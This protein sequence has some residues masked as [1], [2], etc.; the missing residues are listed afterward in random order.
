[1]TLKNGLKILK[2]GQDLSAEQSQSVFDDIFKGGT[3]DADIEELLVGLKNKGESVSEIQGAVTSMR[4]HMNKIASPDGCVDI[5]GTGGDGHSTLNVSTAASFVVAGYGVP[6][7]KHGNRAASSLSGS[8][9]VLSAL[10]LNLDPTWESLETALND[11]GIVFLFAPNHHPAMRHVTAVRKKLK[12]RTIFNLLGPLTNPACVKHHLIG[13]FDSAWS[14]PMALTLQALA[15]ENAWITHGADAMDE[16]STTGNT[17]V[18]TL[19]NGVIGR[20]TI[21]PE[22]HAIPLAT[23]KDIQGGDAAFNALAIQ[24]LLNGEHSAYRDIVLINAASALVMCG[25]AATLDTG[26]VQA[27][28]SIDSGA[29]KNKLEQLIK[30]TK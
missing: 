28:A 20:C 22:K 5:V 26:L 11:H 4:A 3:S 23:L 30:V 1:M 8:S 27:A 21:E 16:V 13:V 2:K 9:D 14:T 15:S 24:K 18:V 12:T 10:G 17:S 7:A 29:A 25:K 6:V 19:K